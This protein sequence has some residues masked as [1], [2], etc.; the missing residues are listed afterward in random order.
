MLRLFQAGAVAAFIQCVL[1]LLTTPLVLIYGRYVIN[2]QLLP[3]AESTNASV[4]PFLKLIY[5]L[6]SI[7]AALTTH[8]FVD[9]TA[10]NIRRASRIMRPSEPAEAAHRLLVMCW[11]AAFG[12]A[13]LAL[14]SPPQVLSAA[15]DYLGSADAAAI[16]WP[17]IM[18]VG[19]AAFGANAQA[20]AKAI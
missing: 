12:C 9:I 8:R 3:D 13:G 2:I 1:I 7:G 6:T 11:F 5:I 14:Y 19:V 4:V 16:M 15:A 18:S 10:Q 17:G 20:A